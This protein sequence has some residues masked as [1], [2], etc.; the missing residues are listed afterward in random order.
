MMW[1][2]V[3]PAF[4]MV[5]WLILATFARFVLVVSGRMAIRI[6]KAEDE[7]QSQSCNSHSISLL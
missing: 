3:L 5:R 4:A 1:T 7:A 6:V 2:F